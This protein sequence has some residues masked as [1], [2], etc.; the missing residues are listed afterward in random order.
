MRPWRC[1][2][3]PFGPTNPPRQT[4]P[5]TPPHRRRSGDRAKTGRSRRSLSL[6]VGALQKARWLG[7][8]HLRIILFAATHGVHRTEESGLPMAV[9]SAT[10]FLA[11][12]RADFFC[13][14]FVVNRPR[15]SFPGTQAGFAVRSVL[16]WVGFSTPTHRSAAQNNVNPI[17]VPK[18]A[19]L[20]T[21][22]GANQLCMLFVP[23][24]ASVVVP[25]VCLVW[26]AQKDRI[27]QAHPSQCAHR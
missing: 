22:V 18:Q 5:P 12:A 20:L 2:C 3:Q 26:K 1:R 16:G 9:P 10:V 15:F 24:G 13:V 27:N 11:D 23:H 19:F 21:D 17:T 7:S 25:C 14:L 4:R 8:G 6:F